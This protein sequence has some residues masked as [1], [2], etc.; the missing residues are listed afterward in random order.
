MYIIC[1]N[2]NNVSLCLLGEVWIRDYKALF[3]RGV[4]VYMLLT[5][6]ILHRLFPHYNYLLFQSFIA[7]DE[8]FLT[9]VDF[10]PTTQQL[11]EYSSCKMFNS[12]QLP[13]LTVKIFSACMFREKNLDVVL[14]H[15]LVHKALK[16]EL[17][18]RFD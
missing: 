5:E 8:S 7:A 10:L 15:I 14:W 13:I 1:N 16:V 4:H 3:T 12:H 17:S 6:V 9:M 11:N 2:Y 18:G